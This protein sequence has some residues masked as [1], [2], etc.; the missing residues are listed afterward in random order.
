MATIT[1]STLTTINFNGTEVRTLKQGSTIVYVKVFITFVE[2]GGTGVSDKFVYYGS[3]RTYGTLPSPSRSGF[4]FGGWWTGD[5]GTG[6][7][8]FS[9]TTVTTTSITQTLY[10]KWNSA[11]QQTAA[12]SVTQLQC[13]N[14]QLYA[15]VRW[16]GFAYPS[17]SVEVSRFPNFASKITVNISS[18]QTV[19][20]RSLGNIGSGTYTVYARATDAGGI[21]STTASRTQNVGCFNLEF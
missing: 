19:N 3:G 16:D 7:R 2:N 21:T 5:N 20:V 13:V 15:N 8:I 11:A 9:S 18:G 4:T 1:T 10:A 17:A 14:N 12:P 6:T